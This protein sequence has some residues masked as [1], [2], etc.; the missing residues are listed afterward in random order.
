[1]LGFQLDTWDYVTFGAIAV[2]VFWI[3][4]LFDSSPGTSGQDRHRP[5]APGGRGREPDGLGRV[6]GHR[7]LDPGPDMGLQADRR[8]RH[9]AFSQGGRAGHGRGNPEALRQTCG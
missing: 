2:I 9:P 4:A 1:M 8:G 7:A 5:Q 3:R 6:S